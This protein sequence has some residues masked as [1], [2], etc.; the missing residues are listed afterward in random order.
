MWIEA[1]CQQ[2]RW[3]PI[4]IILYWFLENKFN[5][6]FPE[7]QCYVSMHHRLNSMWSIKAIWCH[8]P[9][10]ALVHV[11][12]YC[13]KTPSHY[14]SKVCCLIIFETLRKLSECDFHVNVGDSRLM[15]TVKMFEKCN[16][17]HFHWSLRCELGTDFDLTKQISISRLKLAGIHYMFC[18]SS[19]KC[20]GNNWNVIAYKI[21]RCLV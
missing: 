17:K 4:C 9:W 14:L 11:M 5:M 20:Q 13:L 12:G 8:R 10:S 3:E 19:C 18:S 2:N 21:W 6:M 7:T 15:F 1:T 16:V